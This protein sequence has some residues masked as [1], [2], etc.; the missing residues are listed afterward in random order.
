MVNAE[1]ALLSLASNS[2]TQTPNANGGHQGTLMDVDA[3]ATV[4][5]HEEED[6]DPLDLSILH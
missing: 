3:P 2:Q 5:Q 6:L 4:V 1:M